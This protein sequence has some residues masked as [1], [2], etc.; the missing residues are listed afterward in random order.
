L[1]LLSLAVKYFNLMGSE[2][3]AVTKYEQ[4][5]VELQT[6]KLEVKLTQSYG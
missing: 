2:A 6:V 5:P 1:L 4:Q 3:A